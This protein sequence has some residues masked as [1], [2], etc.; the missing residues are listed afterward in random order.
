VCAHAYR[1]SN[2]DVLHTRVRTTGVHKHVF[3][4]DHKEYNVYDVGGERSERKKWTHI[5]DGSP[6]VTIFISMS[7]YDQVLYEDNTTV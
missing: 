1:P 5:I 2:E 6:V 4:V 3:L 7:C